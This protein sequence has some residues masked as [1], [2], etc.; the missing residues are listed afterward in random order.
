MRMRKLVADSR[1]SLQISS[2]Q[3][4]TVYST[5]PVVVLKMQVRNSAIIEA[6]NT[7][8]VRTFV[9]SLLNV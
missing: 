7:F 1:N 4:Y 5:G 6:V 2:G 3:L 9:S 8:G